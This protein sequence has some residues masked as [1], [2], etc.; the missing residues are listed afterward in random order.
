MIVVKDDGESIYR[1]IND[2]KSSKMCCLA[3][4]VVGH[5]LGYTR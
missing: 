2:V 5:N 3:K 1:F 4:E